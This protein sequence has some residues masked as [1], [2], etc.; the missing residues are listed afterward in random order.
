MNNDGF[1]LSVM[2]REERITAY[3]IGILVCLLILI[4]FI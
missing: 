2:T 4:D 3:V 1:W